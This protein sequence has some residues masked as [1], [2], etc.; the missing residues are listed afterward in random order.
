MKTKQ[1][2]LFALALFMSSWVFS[3][4]CGTGDVD[5]L[6]QT[7]VD[8]FVAT[9]SGTCDT[10]DGNLTFVGSSVIDISGLSFLTTINGRI[11]F[12]VTGLKDITGLESISSVGDVLISNNSILDNVDAFSGLTTIDGYLRIQDNDLLTNIDGFSGLISIETYLEISSNEALIDVDGFS[13]LTSIGSFLSIVNND[14]LNNVDGFSG[15]T[16]LESSLSISNNDE[17][18]NLDGFG[19]LRAIAVNLSVVS[20][21][22]LNDCCLL[23]DF[24]NGSKYVGGL[25]NISANN[26]DC[27]S[28]FSI[29]TNCIDS[30]LDDDSDTIINVTDNCQTI[31]NPSQEDADNDGVGDACDNCPDDANALQEDANN[32]GIGDACEASGTGADAG[33]DTGGLGI[34]TSSPTSQFEIAQGDVFIKNIHRGVIMKSPSGKCFRMQPN[35]EGILKGIEITCPDN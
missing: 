30:E 10:I 29:M 18:L 5:L 24:I 19:N 14:L 3:Q 26:T 13:E 21:A 7:D 28:D 9:Y 22:S 8:N 25:L 11:F 34:G 4:N 16:L 17:L 33:L 12:N 2:F 6:S 20:N 27:N 15:L 32:N 1:N 23:Y 35:D 31:S